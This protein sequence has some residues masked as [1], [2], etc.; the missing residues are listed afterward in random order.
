MTTKSVCAKAMDFDFRTI[1]FSSEEKLY[2]G[3]IQV[4]NNQKTS[5]YIAGLVKN[6]DQSLSCQQLMDIES[7][8]IETYGEIPLEKITSIYDKSNIVKQNNIIL[9]DNHKKTFR[10]HFV[11]KAIF[12]S[13]YNKE[14]NY[15]NEITKEYHTENYINYD[16]KNNTDFLPI[17]HKLEIKSQ[18]Y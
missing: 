11:S 16:K 4:Q 10:D 12:V 8:T 5:K 18:K 15:K 7:G 9:N 17:I 14:I 6:G 1:Y 13:D 3:I 2:R